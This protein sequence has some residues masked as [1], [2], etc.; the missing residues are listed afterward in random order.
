MPEDH[1]SLSAHDHKVSRVVDRRSDIFKISPSDNSDASDSY[2][3]PF[4]ISPLPQAKEP[5]ENKSKA[6]SRKRSAEH[7]SAQAAKKLKT[8]KSQEQQ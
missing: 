8:G 5:E 1:D 3:S 7:I 2:V 4:A 6:P